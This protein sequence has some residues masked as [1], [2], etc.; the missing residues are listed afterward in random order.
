MDKQIQKLLAT[1]E[2]DAQTVE[3][4]QS[5]QQKLSKTQK[6]L[7][8]IIQHSDK[9]DERLRVT[10]EELNRYKE[11]LEKR[12][13]QEVA[14]RKEKEKMLFQQSKLAAM[15]EM[16]GAIAHQWKQPINILKMQID[17]LGYD[18]EMG[19]FDS[20]NIKKFQQKSNAQIDHMLST[21][22]EFR[23]FFKANKSKSE[24]SV[25][26]CIDTVLHLMQDELMK[27]TIQTAICSD[28]D[29][30]IVGIENEFKHLL[31]N[32][33]SNAKDALVEN[34]VKDK[35]IT[36]CISED[37]KFKRL[38][39]HDNGGGVP[40]ELMESIFKPN[41]STKPEDK[42]TGI[43]LYITS[44]IAYKHRGTLCVQNRDGGAAFIF[45]QNKEHI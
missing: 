5:L 13:V 24:F 28:E 36:F 14:K 20:S 37:E 1:K 35:K 42:G 30:K 7:H 31:L 17:M 15:G 16:I 44:Q 2:L 32:L 10:N 19:E 3:L 33:V 18:Y 11:H 21:M 29:M 40:Q 8:R 26:A 38:V 6:Q 9:Q 34:G 23:S 22:E 12:V 27:H 39:V 45:E 41:V 43:G 25:R 4:I